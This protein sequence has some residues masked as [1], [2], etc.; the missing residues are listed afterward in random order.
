MACRLM[1]WRCTF[2]DYKE[3]KYAKWQRTAIAVVLARHTAIY[4]II[5]VLFNLG[6]FLNNQKSLW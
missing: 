5:V 1:S 4:R 2:P 6:H 3:I